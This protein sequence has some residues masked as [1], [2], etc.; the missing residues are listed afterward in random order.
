MIIQV[1]TPSG[2]MFFHEFTFIG[3][4]LIRPKRLSGEKTFR[5]NFL[6]TESF[7]IEIS[8]KNFNR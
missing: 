2:E 6:V 3:L 4:S 5:S 1:K 7:Y 8:N